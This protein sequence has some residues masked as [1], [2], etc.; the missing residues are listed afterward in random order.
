M[1]N[2]IDVIAR[3]PK[4]RFCVLSLTSFVWAVVSGIYVNIVTPSGDAKMDWAAIYT[5]GHAIV[6]LIV[7]LGWYALNVALMNA[8]EDVMK[9]ADD[10]HC[11]AFVRKAHLEAFARS[12]L[13]QRGPLKTAKEVLKEL[14]IKS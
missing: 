4:L 6:L 2:W 1:K 7:T 10:Q 8:D 12:V 13:K 14:N 11:R 9:F 3:T 5:G